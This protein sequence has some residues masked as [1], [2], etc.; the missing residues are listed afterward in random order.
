[1]IVW[2]IIQS[3]PIL[4]AE[5]VKRKKKWLVALRRHIAICALQSD[6]HMH[7]KLSHST[8][9]ADKMKQLADMTLSELK[10]SGDITVLNKQKVVYW[11]S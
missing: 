9:K 1:M 7:S 2:E 5:F 4:E 3:N 8:D 10:L 11:L 6:Q